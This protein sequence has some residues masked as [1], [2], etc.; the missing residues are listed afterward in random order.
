MGKLYNKYFNY[1]NNYFAAVDKFRVDEYHFTLETKEVITG[2]CGCC[3]AV[4]DNIYLNGRC[5]TNGLEYEAY[6]QSYYYGCKKFTNDPESDDDWSCMLFKV[7]FEDGKFLHLYLPKEM[8]GTSGA[9][10]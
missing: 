4:Y 5:T 3:G 8:N 10:N 7:T 2:G 6:V 1:Y 9:S